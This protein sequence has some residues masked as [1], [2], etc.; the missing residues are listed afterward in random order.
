MIR[1]LLFLLLLLPAHARSQ[2]RHVL[3]NGITLL[4]HPIPGVASVAVESVYLG[5][6]AD[7]P[8]AQAAHLLEH[9]MCMGATAS[10]ARGEAFALLNAR[11]LAN[12]ETLPTFTHYD[13]V[14]PTDDL[15]SVLRLEFERLTSLVINDDLLAIEAPRC[16]DEARFLADRPDAPL[17]KFALM[18]AFDAWR[19][20]GAS[21]RL[22]IGPG[23]LSAES[24]SLLHRR[25]HQPANLTLVIAGNF[26]PPAALALA[27]ETLALVPPGS[28]AP[29]P[30]PR[31]A[32]EPA[33]RAVRW[34]LPRTALVLFWPPP[35]NPA[36]AASLTVLGDLIAPTLMTDPQ[37]RELAASIVCS[38]SLWPVGEVP[39]FVCA[40]LRD[41]HPEA[42][43]ALRE[44][45]LEIIAATLGRRIDLDA[46]RGML[47][48]P[49]PDEAEVRA[50]I[51]ALA[52]RMGISPERAESLV[53]GQAALT[54][55]IREAVTPHATPDAAA[56]RTAAARHL[57]PDDLRTLR[58]EP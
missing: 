1:S 18:A 55:A 14:V 46:H 43:N 22:L 32:D 9:T 10:H 49:L 24:I 54:L 13:A 3:D 38:N 7:E 23:D 45:L 56:V 4:F 11:G 31:F 47:A 41:D 34:D 39:F 40:T 15:P 16:A 12:A 42:E 5:G 6:F 52:R 25:I 2:E 44:R 48:A 30:A 20:P 37:S 35:D 53:V 29:L 21:P 36:D 28:R 17:A 26:D 19:N 50:G 8:T 58:L 51:P 57:A 27:R 33:H